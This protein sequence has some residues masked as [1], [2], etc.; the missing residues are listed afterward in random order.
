MRTLTGLPSGSRWLFRKAPDRHRAQTSHRFGLIRYHHRRIASPQVAARHHC[1]KPNFVVMMIG[2]NDRQN[3]R[4]KAPPPAAANAQP[5]QPPPPVPI[6]RPD[7]ER[8]PVAQHIRSLRR[9]KRARRTTDQGNP[10]GKAEARLHQA[11][12]RHHRAL[13]SAGVPVIWVGL[14]SQRGTNASAELAYLQRI[15]P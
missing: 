7:L 5:I 9:H 10:V 15:L 11:H 12:R 2:N 6:S 13:K 3:I 8:Q 14:P 1:Q 4:E